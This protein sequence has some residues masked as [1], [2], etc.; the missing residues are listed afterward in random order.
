[1]FCCAR[2]GSLLGCDAQL[3]FSAD[4]FRGAPSAGF[5]QKRGGC[6]RCCL[7]RERAGCVLATRAPVRPTA[8]VGEACRKTHHSAPQLGVFGI[9]VF[10]GGEK[11]FMKNI[12]LGFS[13]SAS[14]L[15]FA[16][17]SADQTPPAQTPSVTSQTLSAVGT[18]SF[19][20]CGS[21]PSNLSSTPSV[22][23]SSPSAAASAN[24]A[25]SASGDDSTVSYRPC[26]A[27]ECP[28]APALDCPAG[29]VHSSQQCG[30]E[31]GAACAWT[32][33]CSPPRST[34]PCPDQNGCGPAPLLGVICQ[35]GSTGAL[36][37][38]SDGK[39]CSWQRNCD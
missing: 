39:T 15:A 20:E 9:R 16:C 33:V 36:A 28:P 2:R 22:K 4:S 29:T 21:L 5:E 7:A 10:N 23:C 3:N 18:C 13:F 26:S 38:V 1:L 30:S 25:W 37:C 17:G 35:D 32:T 11:K 24:C 6:K 14:L 34:T 8:R 31:N 27:S 12:V 19:A